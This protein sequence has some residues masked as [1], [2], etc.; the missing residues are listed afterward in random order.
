MVKK[1]ERR[2][3]HCQINI[4][5]LKER[6]QVRKQ[7]QSQ[8]RIIEKRRDG[9]TLQMHHR[10]NPIKTVNTEITKRRQ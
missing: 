9:E 5:N 3:N 6:S 1:G 4:Q 8:Q 2:E 7:E 10:I